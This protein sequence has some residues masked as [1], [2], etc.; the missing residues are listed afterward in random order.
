[1]GGKVIRGRIYPGSG[2]EA[3]RDLSETVRRRN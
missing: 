3:I 1:M 2:P